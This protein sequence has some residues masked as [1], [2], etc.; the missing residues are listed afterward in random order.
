M[1]VTIIH[2]TKGFLTGTLINEDEQWIKFYVNQNIEVDGVRWKPG[3]Q[4]NL[5]KSQIIGDILYNQS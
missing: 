5:R 3:E 1:R 4:M 2:K